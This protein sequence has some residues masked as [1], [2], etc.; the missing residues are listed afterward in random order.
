MEKKTLFTRKD[1]NHHDRQ[2]FDAVLHIINASLLL[3][4]IPGA[5]GTKCFIEI[6]FSYLDESLDVISRIEKI[7]VPHL[8]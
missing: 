5:C 2:N 4:D 6:I 3:K 8:L 7:G 1:L